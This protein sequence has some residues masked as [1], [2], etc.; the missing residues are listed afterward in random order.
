MEYENS[1]TALD[2]VLDITRDKLMSELGL[3]SS[4]FNTST[5]TGVYEREKYK[6]L[7]GKYPEESMIS[8][9]VV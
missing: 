5:A 1:S 4:I 3:P 2:N 9:E 8:N 6:Q 7:F